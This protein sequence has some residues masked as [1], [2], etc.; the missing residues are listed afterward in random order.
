MAQ[1]GLDKLASSLDNLTIGVV[2]GLAAKRAQD[3]L[4]GLQEIEHQ[5]KLEISGRGEEF[6]VWAEVDVAFDVEFVDATGQ[7]DSA[8]DRPHFTYGA[9]ITKGGPV[10]VHACVLQWKISDRNEVVGC[11]LAVGAAATDVAR[12]FSGELHCRFQG[13]GAPADVYGDP[14]GGG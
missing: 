1:G 2:K 6:P 11:K 4:E 7:R 5:V 8:F 3:A 9:V 13:Y 10:G 14:I 12:R